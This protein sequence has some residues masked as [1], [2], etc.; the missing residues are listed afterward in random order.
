MHVLGGPFFDDPTA[1]VAT[2]NE[3]TTEFPKMREVDLEVRA[4]SDR[5]TDPLPAVSREA[6]LETIGIGNSL[7]VVG[8][9]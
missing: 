8:I 6:V 5:T 2:G 4:G 9:H 1:G 3:R 7:I